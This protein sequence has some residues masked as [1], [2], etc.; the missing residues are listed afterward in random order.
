MFDFD[1]STANIDIYNINLHIKHVIK[2]IV[3]QIYIFAA[4]Y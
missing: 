1:L 4:Q 2:H 3:P